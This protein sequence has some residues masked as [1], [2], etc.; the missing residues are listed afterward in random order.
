MLLG[1]SSISEAALE[2]A[3]KP[4]D[5]LAEYISKV[6]SLTKKVMRVRGCSVFIETEKRNEVRCIASTGLCDRSTQLIPKD[7]LYRAVYSRN[8]GKTGTCFAQNVP[9]IVHPD[10]E[11]AKQWKFTE[12]ERGSVV[13]EN[14]AILFPISAR[15]STKRMND[16]VKIASQKPEY[17][18]IGVLRCS[19]HISLASGAYTRPFDAVDLQS[20][21]FITSQ[22]G[23]TIMHLNGRVARERTISIVKHDLRAPIWMMR[24]AAESLDTSSGIHSNR[25]ASARFYDLMDLKLA[26]LHASVLIDELD[27]VPAESEHIAMEKTLLFAEV[28][29]PIKNLLRYS[30][31]QDNKMTI[32]FVGLHAIPPIYVNRRGVERVFVNILTN[33]IKYGELGSEIRVKAT[34]SDEYYEV[35]ISNIGMGVAASDA[36]FIFEQSF[37]SVKAKRKKMGLGLGLYISRSIM[38]RHGGD[39]VLD[40]LTS[41]TTFSVLFPKIL[42]RRAFQNEHQ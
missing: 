34:E 12:L 42:T 22:I 29:A 21:A 9:M 39:V 28:I 3:N 38:M 6:L 40:R 5:V 4:E 36:E 35:S 33:A 37:Q 19:E 31:M 20:L 23:P 8:E 15:C 17:R 11:S 2:D 32:K 25:S 27:Q 18:A 24:D 26:A 30:A 1:F 10:S 14:G 16:S 13:G 41:P 7:K